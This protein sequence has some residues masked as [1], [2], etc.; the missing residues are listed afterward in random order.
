[1]TPDLS[2]LNS[3]NLGT[4]QALPLRDILLPDRIGWWPPAPGWWMLALLALV[5]ILLMVKFWRR[6]QQR[7]RLLK[8]ANQ[9]L[10]QIERR[11]SRH[12]DNGQL[13]AELSTLLRQ[14]ALNRYPR[15]QVAGL[16][17]DAWL[18][19]LDQAFNQNTKTTDEQ[20]FAKGIGRALVEQAYRPDPEFSTE[21][22]L[23]LCQRWLIVFAAAPR[24]VELPARP[25]DSSRP[26][27]QPTQPDQTSP[28]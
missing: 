7:Q 15:R 25:A 14:V 11:F 4:A 2:Q 19:W 3:P 22:L 16:I 8:P 5:V 9:Q 6:R 24:R 1:M 28:C 18:E 23:A 26:K 20:P 13:V 27:T 12:G 17:G 10:Q 21:P